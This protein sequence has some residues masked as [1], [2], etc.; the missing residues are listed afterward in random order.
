MAPDGT[1][2]PGGVD[3]RRLLDRVDVGRPDEQRLAGAGR[4]TAELTLTDREGKLLVGLVRPGAWSSYPAVRSYKL[5]AFDISKGPAVCFATQDMCNYR[6]TVHEIVVALG[7]GRW[8]LA[9]GQSVTAQVDG[10]SYR[11]ENHF[12]AQHGIAKPD[13]E[14]C[15]AGKAELDSISIVRTP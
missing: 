5:G 10:S 7:T 1:T 15:A 6:L 2:L 12:V 11:I 3:N 9:P 8:Q 13:Q 14:T 4:N